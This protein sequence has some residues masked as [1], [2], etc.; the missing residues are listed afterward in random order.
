M[1]RN[2][3]WANWDTELEWTSLEGDFKLNA[4]G[5]VK[6]K[7]GPVCPFTITEFIPGQSYTFST[8][9]LLCNLYEVAKDRIVWNQVPYWTSFRANNTI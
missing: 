8:R 2:N 4:Q 7:S 6:P 1:S 9:L 5:K 3:E